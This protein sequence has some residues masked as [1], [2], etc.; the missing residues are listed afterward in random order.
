MSL[1]YV[2]PQL[3]ESYQQKVRLF[4]KGAPSL[5]CIRSHF[6][7]DR[8]GVCDLTGAK[9]QEE[10]YVLSNRAGETI[11]VSRASLDILAN[12]IDVEGVDEWYQ[13]LKAQIKAFHEKQLE[14]A[15][16]LD[17]ERKKSSRVVLRRKNTL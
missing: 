16:R 5:K 9:E 8:S 7:P 4:S 3:M 6:F 13:K 10:I 15:R 14:E 2:S 17:E 1:R 11:K 12:L